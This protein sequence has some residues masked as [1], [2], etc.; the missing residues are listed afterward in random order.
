MEIEGK[1]MEEKWET[2]QGGEA[3]HFSSLLP[4]L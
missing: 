4:C 2:L 1:K 3:A